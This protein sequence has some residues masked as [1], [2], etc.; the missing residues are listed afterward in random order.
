MC[1]YGQKYA[2]TTGQPRTRADFLKYSQEITLD[3][4]TANTYLLLSE[5]RKATVMIQQQSYSSHADRFTSCEQ[6]LSKE[7]LTGRCYWEVEWRGGEVSVAVAYKNISRAGNSDECLFGRNDTSWALDCNQNSYTLWYNNDNTPVSGPQSS[8]VGV[9]LDHRAG[10][11]SFYSV[12]ETMTLLHRVQTT[13]T[14]P[15]YAGLWVYDTAEL[16]KLK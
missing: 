1:T 3:P 10:V 14:Q 4:N 15:L 13:F 8:R 2:D 12:S 16:C 6:V 7:T 5:G 11:L 9:Y